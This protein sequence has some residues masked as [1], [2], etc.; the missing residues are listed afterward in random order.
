VKIDRA[1]VPFEATRVARSVITA[2][3]QGKPE[4]ATSLARDLPTEGDGVT[5]ITVLSALGGIAAGLLMALADERGA[6]VHEMWRN[7]I[8]ASGMHGG[9]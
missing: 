4:L 1:D 8:E 9:P 3:L 6:D 7:N 2:A 5:Q